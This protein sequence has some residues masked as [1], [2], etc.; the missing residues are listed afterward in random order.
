MRYTRCRRPRRK[1]LSC[2][3]AGAEVV[4]VISM[5]L[6]VH[7]LTPERWPDLEAV[8]NA[9]GCSVARDEGGRR[10]AGLVDRLLRRAVTVSWPGRGTGASRRSDRVCQEARRGPAGGVPGRQARP[11]QRR[12][13]VVRCEI[14][15][16]RRRVRRGGPPKAESADRS[17]PRR[18][19]QPGNS[20][21]HLANFRDDPR[22]TPAWTKPPKSSFTRPRTTFS[23]A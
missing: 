20:V 4:E 3:G 21:Y 16:R 13:H 15:V 7:P 2:P 11:V 10:A 9:R 12:F 17:N 14:D 5:K 18:L 1:Y 22:G 6:A 19:R 8:F 23:M